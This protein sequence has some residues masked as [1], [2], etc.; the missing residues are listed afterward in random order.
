MQLDD[1]H[2]TIDASFFAPLM[3][4]AG[5]LM[6]WPKPTKDHW[7]VELK[8]E[9]LSG[10]TLRTTTVKF[11]GVSSS[12]PASKVSRVFLGQGP[13]SNSRTVGLKV[14]D[15][16]RIII[17][18]S[19]QI[20]IAKDILGAEST[21]RSRKPYVWIQG[22][23]GASHSHVSFYVVKSIMSPSSASFSGGGDSSGDGFS[24]RAADYGK[25]TPKDSSS[26]VYVNVNCP[27]RGRKTSSREGDSSPWLSLLVWILLIM[28]FV[29]LIAAA[30]QSAVESVSSDKKSLSPQQRRRQELPQSTEFV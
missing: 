20:D 23:H 11:P 14:F 24:L 17:G 27:R 15:S 21:P 6:V 19:A 8:T 16:D 18:G 10:N 30:C 4:G 13:D 29:S 3:G 9:T 26:D 2:Q 1:D 12:F 22:G 28:F 5:V 7:T 25:R